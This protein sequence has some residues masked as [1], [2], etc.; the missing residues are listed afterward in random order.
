M[1]YDFL[2]TDLK[3]NFSQKAIGTDKGLAKIGDAVVNLSYSV[4]KSIYLTKK[5]LNASCYR[6][7]SKVSKKILA[8]ALKEA[9]MKSF[10]KNRADAHDMADTVEAILAFVWLS[11]KM[12]IQDMVNSLV[13]SLSGDLT[14][15]K[16]EIEISRKAFVDL[17]NQVKKYLPDK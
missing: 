11:G 12:S 17:L 2:I 7:G 13:D 3:K 14:N 1:S 10:S 4:A 9:N 8:G 16:E 6:T 5:Q 15:Y